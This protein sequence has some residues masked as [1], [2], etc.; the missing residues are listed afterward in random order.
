MKSLAPSG[1]DK[2]TGGSGGTAKPADFDDPLRMMGGGAPAIAS[3]VKVKVDDPL[4]GGGGAADAK[5]VASPTGKAAGNVANF[6]AAAAS[7]LSPGRPQNNDLV[8]DSK[9]LSMKPKR[10]GTFEMWSEKR[11]RILKKY[12][13]NQKVAVTAVCAVHALVRRLWCSRTD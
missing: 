5:S 1:G 11:G 2:K 7:L 13:T 10:K 9:R 12:T 4:R 8:P 3:P 6:S